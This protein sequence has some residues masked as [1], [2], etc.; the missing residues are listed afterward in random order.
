[1]NCALAANSSTSLNSP[2]PQ[3]PPTSQN[4]TTIKPSTQRSP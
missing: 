4:P 2:I 3:F 1:M